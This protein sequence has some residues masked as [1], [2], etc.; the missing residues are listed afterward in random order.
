MSYQPIIPPDVIDAAN[1]RAARA[2]ARDG[3]RPPPIS[4]DQSL[5]VWVAVVGLLIGLALFAKA[6]SAAP[7]PGREWP[8][9]WLLDQEERLRETRERVEA[10]RRAAQDPGLEDR[11]GREISRTPDV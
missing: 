5:A 7:D 2:R 4:S 10:D 8:R 3:F 9:E 6:S 11:P 1:R